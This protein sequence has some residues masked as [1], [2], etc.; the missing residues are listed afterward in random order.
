M[1]TYRSR[2]RVFMLCNLKYAYAAPADAGGLT[3]YSFYS[4]QL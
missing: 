3:D 2:C 4:G 1:A